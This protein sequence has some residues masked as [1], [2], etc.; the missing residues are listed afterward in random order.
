MSSSQPRSSLTTT[1]GSPWTQQL[2]NE[3]DKAAQMLRGVLLHLHALEVIPRFGVGDPHALANVPN[4][5]F[6][7]WV[8]TEAVYSRND[9][10]ARARSD[11]AKSSG[12]AVLST[13]RT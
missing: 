4:P 1:S 2:I 7:S 10:A 5:N 12:A 8:R 9:S 13:S 6:S 3:V 11:R